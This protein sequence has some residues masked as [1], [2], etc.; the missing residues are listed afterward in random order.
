MNNTHAAS[1]SLETLSALLG[2]PADSSPEDLYL[3]VESVLTELNR[4]ARVLEQLAPTNTSAY[5]TYLDHKAW[6]KVQQLP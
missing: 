1:T 6:K 2:L 3:K 4:L 5:G